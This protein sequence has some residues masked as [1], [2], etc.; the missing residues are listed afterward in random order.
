MTSSDV[1]RMGKPPEKMKSYHDDQID[2]L[3]CGGDWRSV[4]MQRN[5]EDFMH[6]EHRDY[7]Y[8]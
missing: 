5:G 4:I 6:K 1:E 3:S 7:K 2:H 8:V